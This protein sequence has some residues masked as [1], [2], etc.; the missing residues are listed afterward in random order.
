MYKPYPQNPNY[1]VF[2]DGTIYSLYTNKFCN[3]FFR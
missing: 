1:L 3:Y 2:D